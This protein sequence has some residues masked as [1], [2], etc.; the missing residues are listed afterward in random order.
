MRNKI[1]N[2]LWGL[3]FITIGIGVIGNLLELW[4]YTIFFD[5]WWTCFIII[6]SVIS[7]VQNKISIGN[8]I[9]LAAGI[10]LLLGAQGIIS[11]NAAVKI[12]FALLFIL[13]GIKIIFLSKTKSEPKKT[14][15]PA[16]GGTANTYTAILGGQNIVLPH[17][18]FYGANLISAFGGIE[19]NLRDAIIDH[20]VVINVTAV[21]GGINIYMAPNVNVSVSG[22]PIVGSI[23]NKA[24]PAADAE[25]R[26]TVH[27]TG[28]CMFGGVDIK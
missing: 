19:L 1:G 28:V 27:V 22:V 15:Q 23:S 14:A 4:S 3:F 9:G 26:P 21:F 13:L 24:A 2:L 20:D 18:P 7:M 17:E 5:G 25:N 10:L 16:A 6:P 8:V 11:H 12:I